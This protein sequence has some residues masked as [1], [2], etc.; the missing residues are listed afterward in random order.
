MPINGK[1]TYY[2][3]FGLEN[4]ESDM[5]KIKAAYRSMALKWHPDRNEDKDTSHRMMV[6]VTE[7]WNVLSQ[8]KESY[9]GYLR[10]KLNLEPQGQTFSWTTHYQKPW[11]TSPGFGSF[12]FEMQD[13]VRASRQRTR[14]AYEDALDESI[15]RE[16][17]LNTLN[18]ILNTLTL[19]EL[20][21]LMIVAEKI[22]RK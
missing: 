1:P 5:G 7:I 9:D 4:F 13:V 12:D 11:G 8:K 3:F 19:P 14:R 20:E 22:R 15:K 17:S 10:R 2:E 6:Q 21:E 18:I 16:R